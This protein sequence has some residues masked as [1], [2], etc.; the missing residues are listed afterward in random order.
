M[1]SIVTIVFC[2]SFFTFSTFNVRG[3]SSISSLNIGKHETSVWE[4]RLPNYDGIEANTLVLSY[5]MVLDSID[6]N[7]N[8]GTFFRY[9]RVETRKEPLNIIQSKGV[10]VKEGGNVTFSYFSGGSNIKGSFT[11]GRGNTIIEV[12]VIRKDGSVKTLPSKKFYRP[13]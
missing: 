12:Q 8:S 3:Q 5:V 13:Q 2:L 1:K 6:G 11:E 4:W 9:Q 7:S 10:W